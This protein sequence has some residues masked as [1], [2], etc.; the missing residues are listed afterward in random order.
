MGFI[1]AFKGALS[2][3][4]ANQWLEY[5]APPADMTESTIIARA[6]PMKVNGSENNDGEENEF[7]ISDGS[8][9]YVPSGVAL[10]TLEN[11]APTGIIAEPG[12]YTYTS[13]NVP[14]ARSVFA[15]DGIFASTFGQ[16]WEQFKF[17]GQPGNHQ[18]AFYINL[19]D[20]MGLTF[21]TQDKVPYV[22]SYYKTTLFMQGNGSY[23]IKVIDPV[24]LFANLIPVD[25]K[26]GQSDRQIL[27][28]TKEDDKGI[29]GTL[30]SEFVQALGDGV[31]SFCN[32]AGNDFRDIM[33]NRTTIANNINEALQNQ[34]QWNTRYGIQLVSVA[35]RSLTWDEGSMKIVNEFQTMEKDIRGKEMELDR[36][37][38]LE[39]ELERENKIKLGQGLAGEAG[40]AYAQATIAEGIKEAGKQGGASSI[41]G[42]GVG[43]NMMGGMNGMT[44]QPGT[45]GQM[46]PAAG[47]AAPGVATDPQMT[48][49]M[50]T[51][52]MSPE[53]ADKLGD[54]AQGVADAL[55]GDAAQAPENPAADAGTD[56]TETP[57]A[58]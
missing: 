58:E 39:L 55:H 21:G 29:N 46:A 27:D 43:I 11:G 13:K 30:F 24:L 49:K 38:R 9:F 33:G 47:Q 4:F 16:S 45:A 5:M 25:I 8:R 19:N 20:I 17:G 3:S 54:V 34:S 12:G 36:I 32:V 23:K 51:L 22:D 6:K 52:S 37:K 7:V 10:I 15:G 18:I 41:T 50:G 26:T 31:S 35:F 44:Q 40:N 14:E 56:T 28:F 53:A 2:G 1:Q 42:L 48:A 57:S